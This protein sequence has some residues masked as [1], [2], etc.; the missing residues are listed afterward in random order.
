M[1]DPSKYLIG[2]HGTM[3]TRAN[4]NAVVAAMKQM[5]N[6]APFYG[7]QDKTGLHKHDLEHALRYLEDEGVIY[8]TVAGYAFRRVTPD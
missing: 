8:R 5:P 6:P 3:E 7:I 2:S 4:C 1:K